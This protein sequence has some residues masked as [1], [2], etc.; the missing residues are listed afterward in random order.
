M[1]VYFFEY[2]ASTGAADLA[3]SAKDRKCSPRWEVRNAYIV[4]S[5]CYQIGVFASRSSL[6]L[7]KVKWVEIL[8]F[9]Q[10]V[11]FVLFLCQDF[12]FFMDVWVMFP[13]MVYVGLLGGCSYVN[14]FFL[15]LHS[16]STLEEDKEMAVN[17]TALHITA[18]ITV[19]A[20][21]SL[22]MKNTFLI[23]TPFPG[24]CP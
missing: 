22:L 12:F 24:P 10:M 16:T 7:L 6:K 5:F 15:I 1:L 3:V 23:P 11:N 18:G 2:V 19:A 8:T 17:L 13:L 9:L 20:A 14:T 21:F 4:L